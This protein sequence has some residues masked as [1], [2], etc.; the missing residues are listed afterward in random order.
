MVQS[1]LVD[2]FKLKVHH[3]TR[4]GRVYALTVAKG[5]PK[6]LQT[7]YA[8]PAPGTVLTASGGKPLPPL[9][10]G[11]KRIAA[12]AN[13]A[14][15]TVGLSRQ[16]EIGRKVVDNTGLKGQYDLILQWSP[17]QGAAGVATGGTTPGSEAASPANAPG[18]SLFGAL[19]EQLGL[20]LEST[21]GPVDIL[22]IDHIER[23]SEN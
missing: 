22:V 1:L 3:E 4:M 14:L 16:P 2:R 11:M 5:G 13:I 23:P 15:L 19:R 10:P 8:V 9:P 21:K 17:D 7:E 18:P 20:K 12:H 6:F